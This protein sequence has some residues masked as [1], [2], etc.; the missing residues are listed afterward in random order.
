MMNWLPEPEDRKRIFYIAGG[1]AALVLLLIFGVYMPFAGSDNPGDPELAEVNAQARSKDLEGLKAS[2]KSPDKRVS[3]RAVQAYA[4]ISGPSGAATVAQFLRD[5]RPEVR[6]EAASGWA[7]VGSA[8]NIQPLTRVVVA[9]K[10]PHVRTAGLQALARLQ[11]WDGLG[12]VLDRMVDDDSESVRRTAK[13]T[14]EQVAFVSVGQ[15]YD[16][17]QPIDARR[18]A[19]AQYRK[20]IAQPAARGLYM[21]WIKRQERESAGS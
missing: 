15:K 6:A 12:V 4:Q 16:A 2:A 18:A 11:A 20:F 3:A 14:F 21:D 1:G 13:A 10:S 7:Y 5:P 17:S 19:V 9:D 8:Q